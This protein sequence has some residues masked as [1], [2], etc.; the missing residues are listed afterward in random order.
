M[1]VSGFTGFINE[2]CEWLMRLALLNTLW[3]LFSILG[4][5]IFGWAPATAAMVAV[6]RRRL[7]AKEDFSIFKMFLSVYRKEFFKANIIGLFI[8]AG[9][10]SLY[11]SIQTLMYLPQTVM[12][13]LGTIF[14]IIAILFVI[15]CLFIFPVFVHYDTTLKNTFHYTL[16]IGL[17]HLH[18]CLLLVIGLSIAFIL[19]HSFP[20]LIIFYSISMPVACM[21]VIALKVFTSLENRENE[22][23][24]PIGN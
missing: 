18:Y 8:I 23:T 16:M 2:S 14:F 5:G 13:L 4:L 6:L 20:G 1:N 17:S 19:M 7:I 10:F 21:T 22:Y 3:I 15:A 9:A 11:F 24:N 12:I